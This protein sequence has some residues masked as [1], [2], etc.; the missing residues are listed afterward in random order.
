[1]EQ[2]KL[3]VNDVYLAYIAWE[4]FEQIQQMLVDNDAASDRNTSRGIPR[5]GAALLHGIVS[6]G[7]CGHTMVVQYTHGTR[8]LCKYLRQ[9][10]H[11]PVCQYIHADPVDERVV[12]VFFQALSPVEFDVYA[13]AVATQ[14]ATVQEITHAHQ[15]HLERLRYEAA[16]AQRQFN[17]VDPDN[18]LSSRSGGKGP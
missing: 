2:W 13:A 8:S 4:T 14:Q 7:E 6:C 5:D 18:R 1:M 9:Q 10:Y 15:Q 12:G 11:V 17:R 16:L 3:R